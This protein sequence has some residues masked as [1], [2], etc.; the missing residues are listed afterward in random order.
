MLIRFT[1]WITIAV[2][3]AFVVVAQASF[4]ADTTMWLT[5]AIGAGALFVSSGLAFYYRKHLPTAAP[6][7]IAAALSAWMIVSSLVFSLSTVVTLSLGEGLALAG[8]AVIG[9]TTNELAREHVVHTLET[10]TIQ[11]DAADNGRHA[12]VG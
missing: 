12:L 1:S 4:G 11:A 7:G 3:A 5:F 10:T 6:A 2:A 8:L 9:L